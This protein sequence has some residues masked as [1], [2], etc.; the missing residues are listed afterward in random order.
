MQKPP[1]FIR[2]KL[3][4]LFKDC[5]LEEIG[6]LLTQFAA[7]GHL[8][9]LQMLIPAYIGGM[10]GLEKDKETAIALLTRIADSGD[11]DACCRLGL[12]YTSPGEPHNPK[13]GAKYYLFAAQ[14]GHAEA[15]DGVARCYYYG[16]GLPQDKETAVSWFTKSAKQGFLPAQHALGVAYL[17]GEG[18]AGDRKT[19]V[20]WLKKA[21]A[22]KHLASISVLESLND[23]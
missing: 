1:F 4:R 19:A 2:R 6:T 11:T 17:N 18:V 5:R 9:A 14:K 8:W 12:I 22:K 21:A 16:H 7:N 23:H 10:Y 13:L 3:R 20:K 15:Q